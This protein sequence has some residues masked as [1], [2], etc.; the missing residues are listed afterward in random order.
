MTLKNAAFL[1]LVGTIL[2]TIVLMTGFI[3]DLLGVVRGLIPAMR[4]VTSVVYAFAGLG[5][6]VFLYAFQKAQ[7]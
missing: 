7:S 4:L 1:A 3:D 2:A 5:V 6:V